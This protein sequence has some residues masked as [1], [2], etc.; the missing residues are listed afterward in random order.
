MSRFASRPTHSQSGFGLLEVLVAVLVVAIGLLGIAGLQLKSLQ[1]NHNS[2][3]RSQ[4][5]MLATDIADRIRANLPGA[6]TAGYADIDG[7]EG[8]GSAAPSPDCR[9]IDCTPAQIANHDAILWTRQVRTTLPNGVGVVTCTD[10]AGVAGSCSPGSVHA[11]TVN[12]FERA[13][14]TDDGNHSFVMQVV[15]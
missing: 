15:P 6:D 4:A 8:N 2:Y 3:V 14:E 7:S 5:T 12:W 1:Y 13:S 10:V 9:V 11:I